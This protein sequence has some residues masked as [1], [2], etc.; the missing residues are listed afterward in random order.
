VEQAFAIDLSLKFSMFCD[1]KM[2]TILLSEREMPMKRHSEEEIGAKLRQAQQ[3]M[4][5]GQTQAEACK[6]LGVSVM[7]YHR[8]R[9]LSH[10]RHHHEPVGIET[11]V[12]VGGAPGQSDI[13]DE[14]LIDEMRSENERLRRIAIDLLLEKMKVEE[15]IA[16]ISNGK[17]LK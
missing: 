5:R 14:R 11:A 15:K 17:G 4:A 3:L 9:K 10:A 1:N 2:M 13:A 8:W 7:T 16:T 6:E 12:L